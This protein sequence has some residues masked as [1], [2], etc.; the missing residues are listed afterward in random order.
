MTDP[1]TMEIP[2]IAQL[3]FAVGTACVIGGA[4][5]FTL[6]K[7]GLSH[8]LAGRV[9]AICMIM[10]CLSGLYLSFSRS[11]LF[12]AFLALLALHA[13]ATGWHAA[14]ARSGVGPIARKIAL[15]GISLT[16]I[17]AGWSGVFV[18]SLPSRALN[19]LTPDAFYFLA[20]VAGL[21]SAIDLMAALRRNVG[22]HRRIARHVWR[23]GFSFFIASF[24]FF[25][26][27]N[28]VLPEVLRSPAILSAPVVTV[29]GMTVFWMVRARFGRRFR[30]SEI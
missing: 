12:T 4:A 8:R 20:G 28:H 24:I 5:A 18:S 27:N 6:R 15:A 9:F 25:F 11:I 1:V 23:M 2:V 17:G 22:G 16:A 30:G 29:A 7:G 13:V 21:V 19:G 26:G 3:H 10:L 14:A